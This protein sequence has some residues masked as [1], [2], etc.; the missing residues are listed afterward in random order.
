MT[1]DIREPE[2]DR[3]GSRRLLW[4][5]PL[6]FVLSSPVI[7]FAVFNYCG[8]GG[9]SGTFAEYTGGRDEAWKYDVT[10]GAIFAIVLTLVPW[11]QPLR[12]RL[13]FSVAIGV[14]VGLVLQTYLAG[15]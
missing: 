12:L 11:M 2:G 6:A 15:L 7:W 5:M 3:G 1:S 8:I 10:V 9:C 4:A 14:G 13:V